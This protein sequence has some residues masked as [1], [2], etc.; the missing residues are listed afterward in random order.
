MAKNDAYKCTLLSAATRAIVVDYWQRRRKVRRLI[1]RKNEEQERRKREEIEM[2]GSKND[3]QKF[4]KEVK[5]LT[6]GFKP[7]A[8]S[9]RDERGNLVT[10]AQGVLRLC[11][12]HFSTLLL[13]DGDINSATK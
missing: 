4:F 9:C 8:S 3:A 11:K 2:F 13:G 6:E 10:D 7:G 5:R 12:D 1:R